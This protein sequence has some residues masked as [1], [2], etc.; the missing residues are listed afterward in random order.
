MRAGKNGGKTPEF[1]A[2][3]RQQNIDRR[4]AG[5]SS[6]LKY[7]IL[8]LW[9]DDTGFG[10]CCKAV[11]DTRTAR[12]RNMNR[13][14]TDEQPAWL[15]R[16]AFPDKRFTSGAKVVNAERRPDGKPDDGLRPP[17]HPVRAFP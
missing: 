17:R 14:I 10:H 7:R 9:C 4:K 12:F 5:D 3:F 13:H 1:H 2:R 11:H 15:K 16:Q 8:S 6:Q